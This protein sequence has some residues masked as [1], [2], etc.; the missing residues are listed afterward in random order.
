MQARGV[1]RVSPPGRTRRR[2]EETVLYQLLEKHWASFKQETEEHGGLPSFVKD[3]VEGYLRCGRLEYGFLRAKCKQCGHEE[4]VAFSCKG[5]GFCPSC[6]GRRMNDTASHLVD[7]V[8]PKVPIRQW[9]CSFSW[10]LRYAMG[11]NKELTSDILPG[12]HAYGA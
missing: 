8:L 7:T 2:P 5:R 4:L 12:F 3:E 6:I 10:E 11:Y 9:V 1:H